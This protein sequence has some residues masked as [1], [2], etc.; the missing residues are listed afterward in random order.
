M[1]PRLAS[2]RDDGP[3]ARV[4]GHVAPR[5]LP[6][7]PTALAGVAALTAGILVDGGATTAAS[8]LGAGVFAALG[9]LSARGRA[10]GRLHW[11][12]PPLLHT[13]EYATIVVLAWRA[14]MPPAAFALLAVIASHHYDLLYLQDTERSPRPVDLLAGGWEGRTLV[15][16]VASAAG[17]LPGASVLLAVWLAVLLAVSA[18]RRVRTLVRD[19]STAGGQA[20]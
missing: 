15:L 20:P 2:Q 9:A 5:R 3:L 14:G 17:V 4:V 1:T 8:V 18:A 13:G 19:G 10:G 12:V 11:L 6:P 7:L 16:T